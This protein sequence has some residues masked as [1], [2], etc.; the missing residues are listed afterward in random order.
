[1]KKEMEEKMLGKMNE[2]ATFLL[3]TSPALNAMLDACK[4]DEER[5]VKLAMAVAVVMEKD[6]SYEYSEVF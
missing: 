4:T 5:K 1:M 6:S 2:V 3:K